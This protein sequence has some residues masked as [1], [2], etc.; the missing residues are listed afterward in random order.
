MKG[1]AIDMLGWHFNLDTFTVS[2]ADHNYYRTLYGFLSVEQ[3]QRIPV[4]EIH[5]LSSWASRYTFICPFMTPFSGYLYSAF[6]G[7]HNL[8]VMIDLPDTAY[9]VIVLWRIFFFLMK[10]EPTEFTRSIN[11]FRPLS[12]ARY[13]L[14]IDGCPEGV[15]VLIYEKQDSGHWKSIFAMSWCNEYNL[16]ND[17]LYQNS[18]EFISG[19]MGLACLGWLGIHHTHVE[20]LG[21]NMSSLTW[22]KSLKFRP[23]P[24]TSAA[25]AYMLLLKIGGVE[26]VKTEFRPGVENIRADGLSRGD[27]PHQLGFSDYNSFT[28][29]TAPPEL[30][31]L[32]RL[33]DPSINFMEEETLIQYWGLQTSIIT[34][35]FSRLD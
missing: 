18:M 19:V 27:N 9:L 32:S 2:I 29:D 3:H 11:S 1:R 13:L 4:K 28:K 24:S 7:Y 22:M 25:V 5:T 16:G 17:S 20:V 33:L 21:D 12:P 10:L 26:V 6:K 23:G 34:S 31:G 8:E 30:K 15:G 35:L 14:E